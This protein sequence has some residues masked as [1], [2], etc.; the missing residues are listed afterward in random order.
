M[1]QAPT[2]DII[3]SESS[4]AIITESLNTHRQAVVSLSCVPVSRL[5]SQTR[6]SRTTKVGRREES[7]TG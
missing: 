2:Q 4:E 3:G 7:G 1:E 6:L 5:V